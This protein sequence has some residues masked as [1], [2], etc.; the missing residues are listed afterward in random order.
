MAGKC[1]NMVKK[2]ERNFSGWSRERVSRSSGDLVVGSVGDG[3][4]IVFG[5][6]LWLD[7]LTNGIFVINFPYD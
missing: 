1:E 6:A 7:E 3:D 4:I 5:C 2:V